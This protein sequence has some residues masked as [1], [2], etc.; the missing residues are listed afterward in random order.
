MRRISPALL[1][2]LL[3]ACQAPAE[4]PKEPA[5]T[6]VQSGGLERAAIESGV[7]AD[8]AHVSPVGLFQRRHEAG[9]DRLC[10]LPDTGRHFRFGVEAIFGRDEHCRGSGT[11][12]RA[13]DKLILQFSG[14]PRCIIVAQ[15]DGDRI[16]MPGV[17]DMNCARL[18]D[19]RGSLEGVS[20]PRLASDAAAA[21]AAHSREN[22]A[23][24]D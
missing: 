3:P 12:R 14:A 23:L 2:L 19:G 20:L 15:Y 4:A 17:V 21:L 24:C 22:D 11:A 5:A 16:A 13:G 1:G 18:C 8:P 10:V 6:V 9:T 7:I